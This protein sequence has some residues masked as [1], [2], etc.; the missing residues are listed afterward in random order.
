MPG[1]GVVTNPRSKANRRDPAGMHRLAYLL[2]ARGETQATGSLDDLYRAA[3]QFKAAGIDVLGIH[4]GDGTLHVTLSA[5]IQV[6]GDTP[7]PAVAILGGGTLNTIMRGLRIRG[8][9]QSILYQVIERY[10]EGR[11]LPTIERPVMRIGAQHGFIFGTGL[12]AN[13]LEAYYATG[14]PSPTTGALLLVRAAASALVRGRFARG[15]ARRLDAR[16]RVDGNAWPWTDYCTVT[17]GTVPE[18]GIGFAPYARCMESVQH[19]AYVGFHCQPNEIVW[20][21]PRIYRGQ[22]VAPSKA[23]SGLAREMILEADEPM[24]YMIDGDLH[25]H[26]GGPLTIAAGP[27]LRIVVPDGDVAL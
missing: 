18:I 2:G 12:I 4:G 26:E 5:F 3:E 19:F 16:V 17:C 11:E 20:E 6:Y 25:T 15:L 9:P 1:I 7:L 21:L 14:K 8:E 24:K 23:E 13:F 27:V 10:H 22:A